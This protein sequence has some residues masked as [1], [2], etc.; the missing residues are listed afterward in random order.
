MFI[1]QDG[2]TSIING[3]C[4]DNEVIKQVKARRP[5]VGLLNPPYK[6]DKKND[7]EELEFVL[8]NLDCL[9]QG[10]KCVAI[11]PMQSAIAQSGKI[12]HLKEKL[13]KNHTLEGVFSM[14]NEL[15]FNSKVGVV[16]CVML[17][18]AKRPHPKG[19][20]S[21]F[22]YFKDDGYVIR[23]AKGRVDVDDKFK[24]VIL[25]K[26]VS[27]YMNK[28]TI[29]SFSVNKEVSATDEW[30]AE[31]YMETDY[32]NLNDT[33]FTNEIKKYISYRVQFL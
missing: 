26:W 16:S 31:A 18:T 33:E 20:K 5:N 14:P 10:G 21:F 17:F 13:L 29:P 28:E 1:H 27:T 6:S 23:R 9:E 3:D 12:A 32:S 7:T 24:H 4:F 8:S 2:K 30:C 15:F 25:D 19:K 22:G 11:V